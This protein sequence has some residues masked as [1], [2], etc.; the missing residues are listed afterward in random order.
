MGWFRGV[1]SKAAV[2]E[3]QRGHEDGLKWAEAGVAGSRRKGCGSLAPLIS[4][5]LSVQGGLEGTDVSEK[6][7]SGLGMHS[8]LRRGRSESLLGEE[9]GWLVLSRVGAGGHLGPGQDAPSA[10]VLTPPLVL[11]EGLGCTFLYQ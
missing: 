9:A 3:K 4:G 10:L 1:L 7:S 2:K 5:D 6:S 11:Q 8:F